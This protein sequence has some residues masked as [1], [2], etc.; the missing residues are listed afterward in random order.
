VSSRVLVLRQLAPVP[1]GHGIEV[2]FYSKPKRSAWDGRVTDYE[3]EVVG[4]VAWV[5]DLD[6]GVTYVAEWLV[7]G[8]DGYDGQV[9]A[10]LKVHERIVGRVTECQVVTLDGSATA[11]R[12]R[13]T[14]DTDAGP[15]GYRS[16]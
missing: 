3:G 10:G 9:V 7:N 15:E 4:D 12:T 13:L 1:P 2:R 11:F 6:T 8:E 14:I 5:R 16:A